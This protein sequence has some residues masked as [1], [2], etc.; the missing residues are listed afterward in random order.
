VPG[1]TAPFGFQHFR[2]FADGVVQ[3]AIRRVVHQFILLAAP[4]FLLQLWLESL[5]QESDRDSHGAVW[6]L[7]HA[8]DGAEKFFV[9]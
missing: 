7:F 1:G 3:L 2:G 8:N 5:Q 9:R 6:A 4:D